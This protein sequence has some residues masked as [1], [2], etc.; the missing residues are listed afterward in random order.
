M[1]DITHWLN[2]HHTDGVNLALDEL[3]YYQGKTAMLDLK[4]RKT[5]QSKL[6][7]TYLAKTRG[8]GM[9]FDEARHYQPG[10]DIRAIDWRV[11]ARTGKT[12]TKLYREEKERPIFVLTDLSA[13]MHFGTRFVFKSVQAAHLSALIAWAARKRGDRIGGLIYN[14]SEHLEYKPMT[15]QKAVLSLLNGLLRLHPQQTEQPAQ[16]SFAESCARMRRM[17]HPGSL[18]FLISDFSQFDEQAR[19]HLFQLSRHCELVAYPISDPFEHELPQVRVPQDVSITDG[20]RT[21]SLT[22][23]ETTTAQ[24]Y[25]ERH[26]QQLEHIHTQLRQCR[27][28]VLPISAGLS[29]EQQLGGK[30]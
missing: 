18:I 14:Q 1:Q 21:R 30:L 17:A 19:Q 13:S 7:G 16:I 22:L 5:I 2:R 11:T 3:L 6:A 9:E 20:N 4:P 29:L 26:Q 25:K 27:C 12:H 23:G 28:Q 10:D 15:R 24:T 8:R